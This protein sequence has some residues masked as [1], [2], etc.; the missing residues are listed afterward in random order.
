MTVTTRVEY[1]EYTIEEFVDFLSDV[2][3]LESAIN[4]EALESLLRGGGPSDRR[5]G[6]LEFSFAG[7]PFRIKWEEEFLY[8]TL[9]E[10]IPLEGFPKSKNSPEEIALLRL[11]FFFASLLFKTELSER[12]QVVALALL[13]TMLSAATP[14]EYSVLL[15]PVYYL[16]AADWIIQSLD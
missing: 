13:L 15:E 16:A 14:D 7:E 2:D 1:D 11:N 5:V 9:P 8:L 3:G 12:Q 10:A 6:S 4:V